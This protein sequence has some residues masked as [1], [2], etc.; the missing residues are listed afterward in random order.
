MADSQFIILLDGSSYK[1]MF[2]HILLDLLER[3]NV[4]FVTDYQHMNKLKKLLLK[5][6]IRYTS[7]GR[8]DF[9]AYEENNLFQ[10]IRYYSKK[11]DNVYIIFLNAALSYNLY[12]PNTLRKYKKIFKNLKYILFYLDIMNVPVSRNAN[13]LREQKIFDLVYTIDKCDAIKN[14]AV[15]WN[16][17][18]SVNQNYVNIQQ[19]KDLYFCGVSKG[20]SNIL[21]KCSSLAKE[22]QIKIEM[23]VICYENDNIFENDTYGI[24]VRTPKEYLSYPEVIRNEL[25]AKCILD[26]VQQG[27]VALT[28]RPYEAVVYNRKLLTNNK[29]IFEFSYYNPCWMKYFEKVEDIDWDWIKEEIDVNYKYDGRFSPLLLLN[30]IEKR[31]KGNKK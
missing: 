30:D 3:P 9:L 28:L 16:T 31:F 13:I 29:S 20:R 21:N 17:F 6:K 14:E 4:T 1:P 24:N 5:R 25:G 8:I 26:V 19:E 10:T 11:K 18:Y 15:L 22:Y 27:Q 12:L 23:D 2:E 7:K